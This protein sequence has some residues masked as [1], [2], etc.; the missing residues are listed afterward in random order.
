M[1]IFHENVAVANTL[2]ALLYILHVVAVHAASFV[3]DTRFQSALT[4][5][6]DQRFDAVR[7]VVTIAPTEFHST[8]GFH[9]LPSRASFF[10]IYDFFILDHI[11]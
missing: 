1:A 5:I 9:V 11:P 2:P 10:L 7:V 6:I 8:I 3:T 4:Y